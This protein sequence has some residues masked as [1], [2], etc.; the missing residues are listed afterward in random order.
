MTLT[1]SRVEEW[2]S[3]RAYAR[4][5]EVTLSAVQKAINSGRVTAV[6]RDANGRCAGIEKN[7]ADRQWAA[8][9][10]PV[11]ALRNG[12]MPSAV[13][14]GERQQSELM[15][16][17]DSGE[18]IGRPRPEAESGAATA[19]ESGGQAE[20]RPAAGNTDQDD[21]LAAR[22]KREHFQ[23]KTAEIEYLKEI[24]TL[25]AAAEVAGA[26]AVI[27]GEGMSKLDRIADRKAQ[28][29]AAETDPN[30]VHRILR[31]ETNAVRDECS[32]QLAA[33]AAGGAEERETALP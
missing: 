14:P 17:R 13:P 29:L 33:L 18:L 30:R 26:I 3:L 27:I 31:D 1:G 11:E 23:A 5:R 12:K 28:I 4:H 32:R 6:R 8:N 19:E 7:E 20:G 24:G 15:P 2:M 10:D 9:T 16:V 22:A 21:Y 25:V